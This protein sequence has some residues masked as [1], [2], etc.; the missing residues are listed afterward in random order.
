MV[1]IFKEK[2]NDPLNDPLNDP[3]DPLNNR[4]QI[5]IQM[6]RNNKY[7]TREEIAEKCKVSLETIKRDISKMQK[8]KIIKRIGSRKT[9]YWQ[10]IK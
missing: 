8:N 10:I 6:I 3:Y 4:E 9:G 7:V 2:I 5:T 1:I